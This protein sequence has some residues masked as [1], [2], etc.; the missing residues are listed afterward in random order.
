MRS[1]TRPRLPRTT[2]FLYHSRCCE[3][4]AIKDPCERSKEDLKEGKFSMAALGKWRCGACK[5]K[6]P[7]TRSKVKETHGT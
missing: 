2:T 7:V 5:C 4:P 3:A 6:C 1:Q